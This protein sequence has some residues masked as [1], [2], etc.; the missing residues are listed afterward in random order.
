[1]PETLYFINKHESTLIA[2]DVNGSRFRKDP[3]YVSLTKGE[4]E[5]LKTF[6]IQNSKHALSLKDCHAGEPC[7]IFGNGPS[8]LKHAASVDWKDKFTIGVNAAP[9]TIKNLQ[10][11]MCVEDFYGDDRDLFRWIRDWSA[12]DQETRKIVKSG[13]LNRR[14]LDDQHWK[15]FLTVNQNSEPSQDLRSQ[16]W[17]SSTV[18]AAIELARLMG[19]SEIYLWG[20]DYSNRLHSYSGSKEISSDVNDH[21]GQWSRFDRVVR[22]FETV[23]SSVTSKPARAGHFKTSSLTERDSDF[24]DLQ[25]RSL[26]L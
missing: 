1:M 22:H 10:Y 5:A 4:Y 8:L 19:A 20:I 6:Q 3:N 23:M 14:L 21:S 15:P 2:N 17:G 11:W 12:K 16:F 18:Q 24:Y 25:A 26:S 9:V 7:H 13:V